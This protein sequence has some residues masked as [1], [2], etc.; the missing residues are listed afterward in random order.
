MADAVRGRWSVENKLHWVLD[1][2]FAENQARQRTDH[3][4]E[5]F[6]RLRRIALNLLRR[7]TTRK[8][9]M[10][11]RL[12]WTTK[13]P[14]RFLHARVV[15]YSF[16][17]VIRTVSHVPGSIGLGSVDSAMDRK[18]HWNSIYGAKPESDMSWFEAEPRVSLELI[19]EFCPAGDVIDIG[20]GASVLVDRLLD[21]GYRPT[22]LDISEAALAISQRRLGARG[23]EVRW[24]VRDVLQFAPSGDFDVWHDRAAFHFLIEAAD[25]RK[26]IEVAERSVRPGGHL[27]LG[28]FALDGPARCSGLPVQRYNSASLSDELGA[29]FELCHERP[30]LHTTP[31]GAVQRFSW[32]AFRR[33]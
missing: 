16:A 9:G 23:G 8:R 24:V 6:S 31:G 17:E 15:V 33:R 7:E 22:V 14:C 27:I 3:G 32:S 18:T 13:L 21:A 19:G 20:G 1:V 29:A 2:S 30:E 5:N 12:P 10:R 4:G 26:Y 11:M 28:T 25:R